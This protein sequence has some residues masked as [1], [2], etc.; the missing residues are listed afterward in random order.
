MSINPVTFGK[1][2]TVSKGISCAGSLNTVASF[3]EATGTTSTVCGP[4][5]ACLVVAGCGLPLQ[6]EMDSVSTKAMTTVFIMHSPASGQRDYQGL[7]DRETGI[8]GMHAFERCRTR[9]AAET[10]LPK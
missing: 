10:R 9:S 4:A 6:P 8:R 5:S 1:I 7:Q 3:C 2:S